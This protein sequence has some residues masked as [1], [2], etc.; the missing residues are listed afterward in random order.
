MQHKSCLIP[1]PQKW[2][3][4]T[5]KLILEI[6]KTLLTFFT[7]SSG[8]RISL[9]YKS[10]KSFLNYIF[11]AIFICLPTLWISKTLRS[12]VKPFEGKAILYCTNHRLMSYKCQ[13]IE[14][15]VDFTQNVKP[16]HVNLIF[17]ARICVKRSLLERIRIDIFDNHFSSNKSVIN[18]VII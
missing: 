10:Q 8:I 15:N 14:I 17:F 11:V 16:N 4:F 7:T 13:S 3:I 2:N 5:N 6:W 18:F 12:E 1:P 9:P